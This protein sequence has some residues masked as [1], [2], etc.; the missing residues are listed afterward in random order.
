VN[1]I[2][3][4]CLARFRRALQRLGARQPEKGLALLLARAHA[5]TLRSKVSPNEAWT[6][7]DAQLQRQWA[8]LAARRGERDSMAT[9]STG[10]RFVCDAGLGGLARWLRAAGYEAAWTAGIADDALLRA[11]R[12]QRALLLTTDSLLL[13]RRVIREGTIPTLWLPPWG[14]A[15]EQLARVFR[16]LRLRPRTPRCMAC[17]GEL[18]RVDKAA[19]ASRIPPRTARWL[20]L[21][22]VCARCNRLFWHGTHWARITERLRALGIN[23]IS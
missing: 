10:P 8:R 6:Q 3:R 12:E 14:R 9:E 18:W 13:E 23:E 1:R 20:D 21:Y 11:A 4:A 17:G 16:E 2:R 5:Q 19:V 22:F 7:L 15:P